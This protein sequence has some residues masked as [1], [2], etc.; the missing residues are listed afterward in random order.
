MNAV[1]GSTRGGKGLAPVSQ[2]DDS[3]TSLLRGFFVVH[4]T[5]AAEK[6]ARLILADVPHAMRLKAWYVDA[7]TRTAYHTLNLFAGFRVKS[8]A[9]ELTAHYVHSLDIEMT[10]NG[11]HASRLGSE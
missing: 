5:D 4:I 8:P 7:V 10:M 2:K 1:S 9:L 6:G 3:L 11:D